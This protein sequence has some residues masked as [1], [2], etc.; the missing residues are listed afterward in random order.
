MELNILSERVRMPLN[1]GNDENV[2]SEV[3]FTPSGSLQDEISSVGTVT[4]EDEWP[5]NRPKTS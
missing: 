2:T 3:I 4:M 1:F 5:D